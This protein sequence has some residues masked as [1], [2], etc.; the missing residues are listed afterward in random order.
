[1]AA[2]ALADEDDGE[3]SSADDVVPEDSDPDPDIPSD[4]DSVVGGFDGIEEDREAEE[5][6]EVGTADLGIDDD[7]GIVASFD[8]VDDETGG[9]S[10]SESSG[11]S[12]SSGADYGSSD[13]SIESAIEEGLAELAAV[14]LEGRERQNVVDE[15]EQVAGKFKVGYFGK[16]VAEKYLKRDLEDIPPELGLVGALIGFAA[17]AIKKRPDGE[18]RLN[19]M[20]AKFR[21]AGDDEPRGT[22]APQRRDGAPQREPQPQPQ[23]QPA[24]ADD[25]EVAEPPQEPDQ[26][27]TGE[28]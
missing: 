19:E 3:D 26:T 18:E 9:G 17:F 10:R 6:M 23:P 12:S 1:M 22:P 14:G 21:G 16:E 25:V 15:M 24:K 5:S 11:S 13:V 28:A 7:D 4:D 27:S 20:V 8:G 2:P